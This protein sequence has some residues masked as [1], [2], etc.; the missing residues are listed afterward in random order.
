MAMGCATDLGNL[1]PVN[2]PSFFRNAGV[3]FGGS[4]LAHDDP[5]PAL[6]V[7]LVFRFGENKSN[8][9]VSFREQNLRRSLRVANLEKD[10]VLNENQEIQSLKQENKRLQSQINQINKRLE[11]LS[12]TVASK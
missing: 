9:R 7:G 5:D 1:L 4:F 3:N 12:M 11:L 10:T 8:S 2:A 6:K